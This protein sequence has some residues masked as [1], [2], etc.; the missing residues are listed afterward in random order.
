M[1]ECRGGCL[2]MAA[3]FWLS[4]A[5]ADLLALATQRLWNVLFPSHI[6]DFTTVLAC[7]AIVAFV[8][9]A[10]YSVTRKRVNDEDLL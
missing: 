7:Y 8:A 10:I 1:F 3:V 6:V 5:G 2:S 9:L 4:V